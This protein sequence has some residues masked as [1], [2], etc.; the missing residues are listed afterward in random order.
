MT[1]CQDVFVKAPS[2]KQKGESFF[3]I[4]LGPLYERKHVKT[5]IFMIL[6]L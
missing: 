6:L 1:N 3:L 2:A 4:S 5:Q